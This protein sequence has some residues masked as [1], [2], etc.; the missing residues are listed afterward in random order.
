MKYK[1]VLRVIALWLIIGTLYY[2]LEGIWH[3]P[4]GGWANIAMLPIGG[5]CGVCIGSI[6][7]IK[8][9]QKMRVFDECVISTFIVLA[10]EF[11]SGVI[12]NL[13]LHLNIWDY[14]KYLFNVY[15]QICL[16]YGILWFVISP[17]AIWLD[18]WL[19]YKLW[20]QGTYYSLWSIY[21]KLIKFK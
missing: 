3:I 10:I 20:S 21:K 1:A 11:I 15:G 14:S 13:W 2:T 9:F 18:D 16:Q 4:S 19:R 7:Q 6:N 12:L 8:A 5:L 17:F